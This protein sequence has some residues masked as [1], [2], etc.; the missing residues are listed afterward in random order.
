[1]RDLNKISDILLKHLSGDLSGSERRELKA[2]LA[3]SV[4]HR[5]FFDKINDDE[6]LK[7]MLLSFQ[8]REQEQSQERVFRKIE[9]VI[10]QYAA[11][12]R[13]TVNMTSSRRT[14][15]MKRWR[16]AAAVLII[17]LFSYSGYFYYAVS[18]KKSQNISVKSD[19]LTAPQK[20][21][22]VV[23]LADGREISL[24]SLKSGQLIHQGSAKLIKLG[25]GRLAYQHVNGEISE[26]LQ[27]NTLSNPVGSRVVD[28]VLADGSHVWLNSGSSIT[29]PVLFNRNERKVALSGEAYFEV[30]KDVHK[31]FLVAANGT[32]TEVLGT[33]FNINAYKNEPSVKIALM[34]GSIIVTD[35]RHQKAN[36]KPGQLA[37]AGNQQLTVNHIANMEQILAWKN[38]MFNFEDVSFADA[39]R[40]L[41]RWYDIDVI[42][43]RQVPA[44]ELT[45]EMTKDVTLEGLMIFLEK[46]GVHCKLTGRKLIIN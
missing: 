11:D 13:K 4:Q 19:E 15:F 5:A 8:Y 40:Q 37:V 10:K 43:E 21:Y 7:R 41:E 25:N 24:D 35:Q 45:G 26:N 22:A 46:L 14:L 32:N 29:Y 31:K 12:I 17:L 1:M 33:H 6:Q 44:I 36:I 2:W 18:H 20:S 38:G 39:M 34:E 30:A 3:E 27:Y 42:Y 9:E 16:V 23:T 28:I